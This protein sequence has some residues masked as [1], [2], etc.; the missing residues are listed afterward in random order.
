MPYSLLKWCL[1]ARLLGARIAF[2]S[3]GAG[4]INHPV[5][6]WLMRS[7]A[8][9]A[10]YRSYRDA[11]SK[12]YMA[13]IGLDVS[14]DPIYPDVAFKLPRPEGADREGPESEPPVVGVGLMS[15]SGWYNFSDGGADIYA[16]Y[17]EKITRF[18]LW[19]LD[20]GNRVRI[21][22]GETS[23]QR[24]I[25]DVLRAVLTAR[26]G[27]PAGR[28][29]AEPSAS[30]HDLM[31][32]IVQTDIVVATR[33]HN[34]V[35]AL[36]LDRP[37]LSLGYARK[38]DVLLESFGLGAFCQHVETFDCDL[39]IDQFQ[40]LEARRK[41]YR[42]VIEETNARYAALLAR[43]DQGLASKLLGAA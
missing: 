30:L 3:I 29:I 10:S 43:Q 38:N 31:R 2:V 1:A 28:I 18:V 15:Y 42:S 32:Q 9:L 39:L 8:R 16:T 35:C 6:R 34:V 40:A 14:E 36:K 24:A 20:R 7:A 5:S 21:L 4:P 37:T 23:D 19:L 33:F 25:E 26:P 13:G 12:D 11:I 27:L 17:I 41:H 22:R